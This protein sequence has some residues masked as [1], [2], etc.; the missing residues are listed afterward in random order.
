MPNSPASMSIRL[1]VAKCACGLP[2]PRIAPE[3]GLLV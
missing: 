3:K 1:S 2:K